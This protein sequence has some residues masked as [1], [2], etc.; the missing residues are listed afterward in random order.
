MPARLKEDK[1]PTT[2][3]NAMNV[4]STVFKLAKAEWSIKVEKPLLGIRRPKQNP[5]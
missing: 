4:L 1:A 5:P 3:S 2:I